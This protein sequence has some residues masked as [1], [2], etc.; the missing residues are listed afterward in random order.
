MVSF[1]PEGLKNPK[2]PEEPEGGG[3][4]RPLFS[5]NTVFHSFSLFFTVFRDFTN[6]YH[7]IHGTLGAAEPQPNRH[8]SAPAANANPRRHY[9]PL[10]LMPPLSSWPSYVIASG[11]RQSLLPHDPRLLPSARNDRARV[12]RTAAMLA[13]NAAIERLARNDARISC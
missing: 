5:V 10:V 6:S 3:E 13:Q 2:G 8:L 4:T 11:A 9:A 1:R 7:R 12:F